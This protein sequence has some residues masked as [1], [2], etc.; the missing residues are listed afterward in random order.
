[1]TDRRFKKK[2]KKIQ[3]KGE[4]QRKIRILENAY[5]QYY[6]DKKKKKVSNIML[7]VI[8]VAV[9]TYTIANFWLAYKT[10]TYM[11]ST[12]TT[13][14]YAFWGSE[15][16]ALSGIKVS[17]VKNNYSNTSYTPEEGSETITYDGSNDGA[18]G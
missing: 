16:L 8:V 4:R 2:L 5:A 13:C 1:M 15:I 10:G 3:K 9:I 12:L 6:P 11:D 17:K 7:V 18:C 14:F